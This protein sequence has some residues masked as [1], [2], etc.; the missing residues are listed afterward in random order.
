[1]DCYYN[2]FL[3]VMHLSEKMLIPAVKSGISCKR[4]GMSQAASHCD[5]SP[6]SSRVPS[7][8]NP[9]WRRRSLSC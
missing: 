7:D 3:P 5:L 2:L 8:G 6:S 9:S 1:M 4:G